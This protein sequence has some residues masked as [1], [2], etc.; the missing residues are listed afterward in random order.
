MGWYTKTE[1]FFVRVK[2]N[3]LIVY[4]VLIVG[5]AI[6]LMYALS[7]IPE[8]PPTKEEEARRLAK[9]TKRIARETKKEAKEIEREAKH[10]KKDIKKD[11]KKV[12]DVAVHEDAIILNN[13]EST[14]IDSPIVSVPIEKL[15]E[16]PD[17]SSLHP[18]GGWISDPLSSA[19]VPIPEETVTSIADTVNS[20][21]KR[22]LYSFL[23]KQNIF[24]DIG[25]DIADVRKRAIEVLQEKA[26]A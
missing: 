11:I 6:Y 15:I 10:L 20:W 13:N 23:I 4:S 19:S 1:R 18:I 7:S 14:P 22:D 2:R 5:S 8:L 25:E 26:K 3:G 9:E 24:L 12:K 17:Q 21:N 16:R